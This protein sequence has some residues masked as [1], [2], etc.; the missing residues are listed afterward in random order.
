MSLGRSLIILLPDAFGLSSG[1]IEVV[2]AMGSVIL[3]KPFEATT[4][5]YL[6]LSQVIQ[7]S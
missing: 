6:N 3:N 4:V 5:M 1:E 2:T 7:L